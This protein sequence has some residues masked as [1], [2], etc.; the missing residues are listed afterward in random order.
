MNVK[1]FLEEFKEFEHLFD[2]VEESEV[3]SNKGVYLD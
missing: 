2:I 1:E 3:E